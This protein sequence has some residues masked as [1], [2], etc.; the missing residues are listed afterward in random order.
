MNDGLSGTMFPLN[1]CSRA[2]PHKRY[3]NVGNWEFALLPHRD[4]APLIRA[5][6]FQDYV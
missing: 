4:S 2:A 3:V 1:D 5:G 6:L